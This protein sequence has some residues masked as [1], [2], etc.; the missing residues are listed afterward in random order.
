MSVYLQIKALVFAMT[1]GLLLSIIRNLIFNKKNLKSFFN[2]IIII[3]I[4]SLLY[5]Y[6][7]YKICYNEF[8]L[9]IILTTFITYFIFNNLTLHI[10]NYV[11]KGLGSCKN[12]IK[13]LYF[14]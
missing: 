4:L 3:L 9:Y 10:I 7:L 1:F 13:M 12:K 11:K 8:S 5:N 6:I 2:S 14:K